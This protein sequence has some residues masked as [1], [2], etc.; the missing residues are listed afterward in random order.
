MSEKILMLQESRNINLL[1]GLSIMFVI[2]IHADVRSMISSYMEVTSGVEIYMEIFTRILV[3]NAVPMF[4][5]VS[6]FLFFL[7]RDTYLNKFKSR[8]RSLVIPYLFWCFVG[9]LIPFI[10]QRILGL[11]HL[12]TGNKLKLLRDFMPV[13]YVRMFWDIREG[14]PIL[15]PLWFLRNLIVL[16]LMTPVIALLVKKLRIAFPFILFV[17]YFFFPYW[18]AGFSSVGFCWF[19][20]GAYFSIM[21]VNPWKSIEKMNTTLLVTAWVVMTAVVIAAFACDFH[22]KELM[23]FYYIIHFVMI[24]HLIGRLSEKYEMWRL[25]KIATASFFIYVFHEPWMGY[26]A[27]ISIR[28]FQPHGV[29]IYLIPLMLVF[30]TIS[31][32]YATYIILQKMMPQFLNFITGARNK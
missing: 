12:Y 2:F 6:G 30:F 11:E 9:F 18:T 4:F 21:C 32:C 26:I 27:S 16:I 1:K 10:I 31:Y 3:G 14:N 29:L 17:V 25:F 24:Y 7:R 23:R 28:L 15:A 19:A 22:Y 13:D 20:M 5:F 8:F